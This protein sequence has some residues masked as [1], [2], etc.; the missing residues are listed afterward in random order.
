MQ[1]NLQD[2]GCCG[3]VGWMLEKWATIGKAG[4]MRGAG[5]YSAQAGN[6]IP[7]GNIDYRCLKSAAS[8]SGAAARNSKTGNVVLTDERQVS[9]PLA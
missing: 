6:F 3:V 1:H 4:Q 8:P 9:L 2:I 7:A 5:E